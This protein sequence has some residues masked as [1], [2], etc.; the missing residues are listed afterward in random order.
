MREQM[1][2]ESKPGKTPIHAPPSRSTKL[3]ALYHRVRD[4]VIC[5]NCER[6]QRRKHTCQHTPRSYHAILQPEIPP[7]VQLILLTLYDA[8]LILVLALHIYSFVDLIA[9]RKDFCYTHDNAAYPYW[10]PRRADLISSGA[11]QLGHDLG[12]QCRWYNPSITAAGGCASVV[13]GLLAATHVAAMTCRLLEPCYV[14]IAAMQLKKEDKSKATVRQDADTEW[15]CSVRSI[16]IHRRGVAS[17]AKTGRLT[18]ISEEEH[19]AGGVAEGRRGAQSK[20]GES[21]KLEDVLLECLV[22]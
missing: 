11:R 3:P 8:V 21:G 14:C 17:S 10:K 7:S 19:D 15:D 2:L 20:S 22:P 16:D 1:Y 12:A 9:P 18:Q 13:A 4:Y 5:R 6:E